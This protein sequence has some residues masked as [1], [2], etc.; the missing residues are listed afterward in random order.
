MGSIESA[1]ENADG[2][3][4]KIIDFIKNFYAYF[5]YYV[6]EDVQKVGGVIFLF[7]NLF[8]KMFYTS[9]PVVISISYYVFLKYKRVIWSNAQKDLFYIHIMSI[10]ITYTAIILAGLNSQWYYMTLSLCYLLS[11]VIIMFILYEFY[12]TNKPYVKNLISSVTG[13]F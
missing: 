9:I 3:K 4:Q 8:F 13:I 1:F 7:L 12:N 5:S 10:L 11:F 6:P 2:V